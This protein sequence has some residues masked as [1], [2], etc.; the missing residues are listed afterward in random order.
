MSSPS[1]KRF[2]RLS[3]RRHSRC[4]AESRRAQIERILAMTAIER[5]ALALSLGRRDAELAEPSDG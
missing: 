4:N 2:S 5:V 3:G 1:S